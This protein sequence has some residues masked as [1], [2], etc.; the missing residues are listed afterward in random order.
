MP[1]SIASS[2]SCLGFISSWPSLSTLA[3]Q[4]A[5]VG[6]VLQL[7][8]HMCTCGGRIPPHALRQPPASHC[9]QFCNC[10]L[11]SLPPP[12]LCTSPTHFDLDHFKTAPSFFFFSY[13]CFSLYLLKN[14]KNCL[15]TSESE[16]LNETFSCG[17]SLSCTSE[18]SAQRT[19]ARKPGTACDAVS[20]SVRGAWRAHPRSCAEAMRGDS[21]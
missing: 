19:K 18:F 14:L 6:W 2:G 5:C 4:C 1:T 8:S 15:S 10:P 21:R 11:L 16:S 12:P 20:R 3:S 9:F 17:A 13:K 7:N